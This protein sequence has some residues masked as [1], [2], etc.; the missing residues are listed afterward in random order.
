MRGGLHTGYET[1]KGRGCMR[2][3]TVD[4]ERMRGIIGKGIGTTLRVVSVL[5]YDFGGSDYRFSTYSERSV[6]R[7]RPQSAKGNRP[8]QIKMI[9]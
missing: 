7:C 3:G 5:S 4:E 2:K 6:R 8:D 9:D 1:G